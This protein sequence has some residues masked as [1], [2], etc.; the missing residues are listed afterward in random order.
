MGIYDGEKGSEVSVTC[1]KENELSALATEEN[2][3]KIKE[4]KDKLDEIAR[5]NKKLISEFS[6][7]AGP[8]YASEIHALKIEV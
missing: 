1:F 6:Q 7:A 5:I 3:L 8:K 2:A 4:A